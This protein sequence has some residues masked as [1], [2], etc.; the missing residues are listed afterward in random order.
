MKGGSE[1]GPGS[2]SS[3]LNFVCASLTAAGAL[4]RG[5]GVGDA[6]VAPHAGLKAGA[7]I[8]CMAGRGGSPSMRFV[9]R[10]PSGPSLRCYS[11]RPSPLLPP[12]AAEVTEWRKCG[13]AVAAC[14]CCNSNENKGIFG[15]CDAQ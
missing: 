3:P 12:V 9:C 6:A 5:R 2:S 11:R 4:Q 7:V 14:R 1:R 15:G 10:F 8:S 13:S